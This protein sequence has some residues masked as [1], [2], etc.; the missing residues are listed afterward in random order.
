MTP[1]QLTQN[2]AARTEE[3]AGYQTNI[4]NYTRM[5]AK[6]SAKWCE[7]TQPL[8]GLDTQQ[9]VS[10]CADE[11][12]L[13]QAADL[14]FRDKLQMSIRAE[15]IEQRKAILVLEVLKDQLETQP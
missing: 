12:V 2:I 9:M 7:K 1:E 11:S 13:M 15:R 8:R 3:V 6:I 14:N 5:V 10:L 4:D